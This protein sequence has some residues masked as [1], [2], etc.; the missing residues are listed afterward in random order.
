VFSFL[1]DGMGSE[2]REW[3]SPKETR[4]GGRGRG[5]DDEVAGGCER[6]DQRH[7]AIRTDNVFPSDVLMYL[8]GGLE[9]KGICNK[10]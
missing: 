4:G 6:Q 7:V 9:T 1:L 8:I 5:Q 10:F 3:G 2:E